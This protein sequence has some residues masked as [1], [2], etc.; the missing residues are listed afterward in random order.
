[1]KTLDKGQDK[2][3]KISDGIREQVLEPAIKEAK[4]NIEEAQNKAEEII[5]AAEKQAQKL[6]DHAKVSIEHERN[7]FLSSLAQSAKQTL[8]SLKHSIEKHLFNEQLEKII[9]KQAAD[10]DVI[11]NLIAAIIKAIE[12]DG[13]STDILALIPKHAN[14]QQINQLLG[15]EILQKLQGQ[16]VSIGEFSGG[17]QVKLVDKKMTLDMTDETLIEYLRNYVRKDFRKLIF[18]S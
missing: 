4:K 5:K 3:K 12:K 17:A 8:E 9:N 2:I 7:V 16:S 11:A 6:I 13:L 18:A 14:S 1:M 10:P 15:R